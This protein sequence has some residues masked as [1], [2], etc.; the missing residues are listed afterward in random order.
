MLCRVLC[1]VMPCAAE[2]YVEVDINV[3][4]CAAAGFIVQVCV[5]VYA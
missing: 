3:T 4:S 2:R 5:C 1:R